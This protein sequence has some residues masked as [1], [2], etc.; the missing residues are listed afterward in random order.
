[1]NYR[2][3]LINVEWSHLNSKFV[4]G[5]HS[6]P[7]QKGKIYY[8]LFCLLVSFTSFSWSFRQLLF[9]IISLICTL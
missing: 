3:V 8:N 7:D 2:G 9:F 5:N 1:M 4:V 6:F